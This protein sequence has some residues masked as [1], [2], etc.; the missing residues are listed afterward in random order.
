MTSVGNIERGLTIKSFLFSLSGI[1]KN[2]QEFRKS[3]AKFYESRIW[4]VVLVSYN[5]PQTSE[6]GTVK[7]K[8]M[9][10]FKDIKILLRKE[11]GPSLMTI[12]Q[13]FS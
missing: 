6:W 3:A 9:S 12:I 1:N 8:K 13:F 2:T 7:G 11:K 10:R 5:D 4:S